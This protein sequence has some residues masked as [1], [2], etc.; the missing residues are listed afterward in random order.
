MFDVKSFRKWLKLY[1]STGGS[2]AWARPKITSVRAGAFGFGGEILEP[3]KQ[4]Q[5]KN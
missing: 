4:A 5:V 1:R 3:Q 2:E